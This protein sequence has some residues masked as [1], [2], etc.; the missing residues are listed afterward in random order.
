MPPTP[1]SVCLLFLKECFQGQRDF[2]FFFFANCKSKQNKV[3]TI[4]IKRKL[5]NFLRLTNFQIQKQFR[6]FFLVFLSPDFSP[7]SLQISLSF[8]PDLYH[9][10]QHLSPYFLL[11]STYFSFPLTLFFSPLNSNVVHIRV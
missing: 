2:D 7:L 3:E 6:R 4:A 5:F 1:S 10:F 8:S 9:N 11:L